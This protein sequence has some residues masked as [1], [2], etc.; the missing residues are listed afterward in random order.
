MIV[1]GCGQHHITVE[2]ERPAFTRIPPL[3]SDIFL[4]TLEGF[5]ARGTEGLKREGKD[6]T[7]ES[8][9]RHI[10]VGELGC[11]VYRASITDHGRIDTTLYRCKEPLNNARLILDH[12][13]ENQFRLHW[14]YTLEG[15]G[16][17]V[18][19]RG[20]VRARTLE[21]VVRMNSGQ[22]TSLN[23]AKELICRQRLCTVGP[24]GPAGAD[25]PAGAAG[26][27]TNTGASGPTGP[28]G[29]GTTG[30][31]GPT[32]VMGLTGPTGNTGPTGATG[33]TGITGATGPFA[34][35]VNI[36]GSFYSTATQ[37]ITTTSPSTVFTYTSTA[38]ANGVSLEA[39]GG[40]VQRIKVSRTGIYEASYSIQ[41]SKTSGPVASSYTYIWVRVNGVDVPD[42]NG[43]IE[44]NSNNTDTLPIVPYILSL[45]AGDYIEFVAES[46]IAGVQIIAVTGTPG[47]DI[48]SIIVG[49][50]L[51]AENIGTTGPTG[52]TGPTGATGSTGPTGETGSTGPTGPT[53]ATGATGPTGQTGSTGPT[54]ETGSTGPTGETGPTGWTGDTGPT[55]WTGETG[56]TGPTGWTGPTGLTGPTGPTGETGPTGFTGPTGDTGNTG[57]TGPTGEPGTLRYFTLYLDYTTASAL[58]RVYIPPGLFAN[59]PLS[60]GGT[61]TSDQ[62]TDLVFFGLSQI[63]M[64]NTKYPF[65]VSIAGSGYTANGEWSTIAGAN[66]GSAKVHHLVSQDYKVE[67]KGLGL[68]NINGANTSEKPVSGIAAG[69]LATI[70]ILYV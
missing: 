14:G 69:F 10:L 63:T 24:T 52:Y 8:I 20:S 9:L 39:S 1:N 53:G 4:A 42:T 32:G 26:T 59:T 34:S 38:V 66:I 18:F 47:P 13:Q 67:L 37:N 43:R 27:A 57:I 35:A 61:F 6:L 49:V 31:T 29:T 16:D 19:T 15:C 56:P 28:A 45:T 68:A 54:G 60:A 65:A 62:G 70:S 11:I 12:R 3:S 64:N 51:I 17:E 41:L 23:I 7:G 25:G 21:D 48:P 58:S 55:G 22:L 44:I 36:Y 5:S 33:P 50:K 2:K 30:S 40:T 46:T